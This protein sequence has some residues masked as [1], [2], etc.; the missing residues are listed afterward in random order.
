MLPSCLKPY[1]YTEA[2]ALY[3]IYSYL[4]YEKDVSAITDAEFDALCKWLYDNYEEAE[5]Y[6]DLEYLD[7]SSLECGSGFHLYGKIDCHTRDRAD[8][9][10][11]Q[12]YEYGQGIPY[13]YTNNK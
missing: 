13:E 6:D 12:Y 4:Y 8:K 1:V 3:A 10:E 9:V 11:A 7:K 2:I 5:R